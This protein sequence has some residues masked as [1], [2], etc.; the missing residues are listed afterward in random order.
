[1]CPLTILYVALE[2]PVL[3]ENLAKTQIQKRT[4]LAER[5]SRRRFLAAVKK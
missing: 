2:L 4:E 5:R 1:M 3:A